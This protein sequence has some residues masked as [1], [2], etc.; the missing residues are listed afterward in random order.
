MR[1]TVGW[2]VIAAACGGGEAA[3]PDAG[4]LQPASTAHCSYEPLPATARAGGA[5]TPG[6]VRAGTAEVALDLP[7]GSALG[8]NTSR[9][10]AVGNESKVDQRR[11]E[12]SGAFNP[13]VGIETIP[14]AKALALSAGDETVVIIRTDTIFSDD[15]ITHDVAARLGPDFAGKVI[16]ASTH[17]HTAPEQYSADLKLQVGG[18]VLRQRNRDRLTERIEEA[19]RAALAAQVPARVGISVNTDFDPD[20]RVSYDRREENDHLFGGERR[21]DSTLVMIRIDTADGA[22]LAIVPVFGVHSAILDDDVALMSCDVSG[23]YERVLEEQFDAPVTVMHL[24]GAAGDVLATATRHVEIADGELDMDFAMAESNA[25]RALPELWAAWEAAGQD[26]RDE[27]A[28]EMVTRSV[29]L[30]PDWRTFTVRGGALEYAP[31]AWDRPCDRVIHD[32]D[33]AIASPIDE[34]NAYYG[35]G[36]CGDPSDDLFSGQRMPNVDDLPAYHSCAR[37]PEVT[38]VLGALLDAPFEG[39]PICASTRTTVSALRLGDYLVITAPGEPLVL[40]AQHVRALSPVAPDKTIVLGYAQGHIG[41]LLTADD[42]LIGGFEPSINLWGPLEGEYIAERAAEVAA[43]AV[44]DARED[45]AAGGADRL[46]SPR[47]DDP[48]V[49]DDAPLAGTVPDAVPELVYLRGRWTPATGQPAGTI[50]RVAGVARFVWIGEDPLAGTPRVVLERELDGAFVPVTRRSGRVVRDLDLLVTWTPDPLRADGGEP[51]THYWAV[52]WQAVSWELGALAER[53]AVPLGRYRFAIEGTGYELA[54]RPFQVV[55]AALAVDTELAGDQLTV[56]AHYDA[57]QGW[58][59]LAMDGLSNRPVPVAA[60]PLAVEILYMGGASE[61]IA[62]ELAAPG[63]ATV[64]VAGDVSE[65]RV[66]DPWGNTGLVTPR[67]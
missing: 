14:V 25:R 28:M 59:L 52:E 7:V 11:P 35:A 54:S 39:P 6:A 30:G 21:K 4:A 64:T 8:G 51:Q 40:W 32:G 27:L 60:G 31:F 57:P 19:A 33:G 61:T 66:T 9:A 24:Q 44:T 22:P 12:I 45:A 46:R 53:P 62:A 42:W 17:T 37:L 41:Y 43:L 38:D 5:V 63:T 2:L 47:L 3:E 13:S 49:A 55:P 15:T 29:E 56:T 58:R 1:R 26:L 65:V 48:L 20:H 50:P 16:W 10:R 18:G 23:M 36:L 67:R 34:F